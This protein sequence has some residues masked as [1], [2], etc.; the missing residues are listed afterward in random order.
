[1]EEVGKRR[2]RERRVKRAF[3]PKGLFQWERM[4]QAK[5][6]KVVQSGWSIKLRSQRDE[7]G[8]KHRPGNEGLCGP[9]KEPLKKIFSREITCLDLCLR[10]VFLSGSIETRV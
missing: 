3:Q 1:M 4:V 2:G 9:R 10:T 7:V 6:L 5:S 8:R